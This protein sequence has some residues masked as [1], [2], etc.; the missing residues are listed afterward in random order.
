MDLV[1]A[2]RLAIELMRQ[3]GLTDWS[4]AFNRA[5]RLLGVC[6]YP[7]KR[8]ELA[9]FYVANNGAETVRETILHE[10]AH[11]LAGHA[12][13]HGPV[14]QAVAIQI[15]AKPER[16][17]TTPNLVTHPGLWQAT[18]SACGHTYHRHKRPIQLTGYLCRCPARAS[19]TFEFQIEGYLAA[20]VDSAPCWHAKCAKCPIV[21]RRTRRP[22]EGDRWFCRCSADSLLVWQYGYPPQAPTK[23]E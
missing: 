14:W 18:C 8:I 3:H 10:I 20:E 2:E 17:D 12:A 6:K 9:T 16:C 11:A 15:G 5:K 19:L 13:G 1:E 22:R 21:Y 4:F 23:S 7:E